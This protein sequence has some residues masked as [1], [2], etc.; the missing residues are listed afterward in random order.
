MNKKK[1]PS[2]G[3]SNLIRSWETDAQNKQIFLQVHAN[4][5]ISVMTC[6]QYFP[7]L[8]NNCSILV[9]G[10]HY[11]CTNG[12]LA[13]RGAFS[14][15]PSLVG[16]YVTAHTVLS[17]ACCAPRHVWLKICL[18]PCRPPKLSSLHSSIHTVEPSYLSSFWAHTHTHTVGLPVLLEMWTNYF[19][20][21]ISVHPFYRYST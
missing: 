13:A 11:T 9:S 21:T 15:L 6:W 12:F 4:S 7:S 17:L 19:T 20:F 14:T 18:L 3:E 2:E 1:K 16:G 8:T 5:K 10:R